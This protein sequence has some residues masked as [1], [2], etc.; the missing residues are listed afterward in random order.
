MAVS[1]GSGSIHFT[2]LGS[3]TDFDTMITQLKQ[4]ESYQKNRFTLWQADWNKRITA[5]Q[6]LNTAMLSLNSTLNSMN[7]MSKFLLKTSTSSNEN[8]MTAVASGTAQNK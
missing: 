8:I 4:I 6:Q 5:F 3:D 2:G 7:T 1:Y